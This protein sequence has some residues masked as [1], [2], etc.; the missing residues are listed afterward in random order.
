[1][2][3][4]RLKY[5]AEWADPPKQAFQD[6]VLAWYAVH[7]RDLPWRRTRDPYAILVSEILLHQTQVRTVLPI[8]EAFIRRFPTVHAL[9]AA[10][11]S[12]V[13]A[14]TDPLGYKVRGHW[15]HET[16]RQ[17]VHEWKG[18]FPRAVEE[19]IRL[20]GVGRYTA[21]AVLSFAFEIKA[22]VLDTN[23]KR[24]LGRYFGIDHRKGDAETHHQ[25]WAL[26]ETVIPDDAVHAFNQ[27]LIDLGAMV[28]TSRK[29]ACL[30]CPLYAECA[31]GGPQETR[32]AEATVLYHLRQDSDR[33]GHHL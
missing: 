6:R 24:L 32:A 28:C 15:L 17:V 25:L 14:I 3:E 12:E 19:L 20:P 18:A 1:M 4:G 22:P 10:D 8:Y 23:V 30:V 2:A 9:A 7:G 13:R 31:T 5:Q 33:R 27:A 16:A 29:P 26:A 11:V 21:G